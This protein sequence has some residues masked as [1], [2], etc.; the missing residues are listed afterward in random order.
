MLTEFDN[1]ELKYIQEKTKI[2]FE[3]EEYKE[4]NLLYWIL[5]INGTGKQIDD[6]KKSIE[7]IFLNFDKWIN[8]ENQHIYRVDPNIMNKLIKKFKNYNIKNNGVNIY[9]C[10]SIILISG[11]D[12]NIVDK[13]IK[14]IENHINKLNPCMRFIWVK[15]P[16]FLD[17]LY[18]IQPLCKNKYTN[19]KIISSKNSIFSDNT[20]K[21][22]ILIYSDKLFIDKIWKST[23][24][25]LKNM[26]K[27]KFL[28]NDFNIEYLNLFTNYKN[29]K[30]I[31]I[32]R[33][34]NFDP[35]KIQMPIHKESRNDNILSCS[36]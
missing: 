15:M 8:S 36:I 22:H 2:I 31:Y 6:T 11:D 33:Y 17:I 3:L 18:D 16:D 23:N 32:N 1:L 30:K 12:K 34:R 26:Y 28:K 14:D 9:Y 5:R 35:K 19:F 4:E 21:T 20:L 29:N 7:T 27:D 25:I 24:I 10:K 13:T